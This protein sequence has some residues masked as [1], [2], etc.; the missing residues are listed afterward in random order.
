VPVRGPVAHY[1][2]LHVSF[3]AKNLRSQSFSPP[4]VENVH[5]D[6]SVHPGPVQ[7]NLAGRN[8]DGHGLDADRVCGIGVRP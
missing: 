8:G 7:P 2:F 6:A 1:V 3:T 4:S 5:V